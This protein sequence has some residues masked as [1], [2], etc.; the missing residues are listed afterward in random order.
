MNEPED[1]RLEDERRR[2][3]PSRH[4]MTPREW[5]RERETRQPDSDYS[6]EA[7]RRGVDKLMDEP[8]S[9]RW[10]RWD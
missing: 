9:K 5:E 8:P 3:P 4:P 1:H 2:R 7:F 6:R 10:R